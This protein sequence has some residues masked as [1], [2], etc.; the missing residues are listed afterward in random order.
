[1]C[2]NPKVRKDLTYMKACNAYLSK[3]KTKYK[4]SLKKVLNEGG[5]G[6]QADKER[7]GV[8]FDMPGSVSS[9]GLSFL[10]ACRLFGLSK[11]FQ[12]GTKV[13]NFQ[14][15]YA[16]A[17]MLTDVNLQLAD[18]AQPYDV[19]FINFPDNFIENHFKKFDPD[20]FFE[21]TDKPEMAMVWFDFKEKVL[22][23]EVGFSNN[24]VI[25]KMFSN[26]ERELNEM[27]EHTMEGAEPVSEYELKV[28]SYAFRVA[29]NAML[30]ADG[31][32][33]KKGYENQDYADRL[34]KY[35]RKGDTEDKKF[36]ALLDKQTL[37]FVFNYSRRTVTYH[38]S[39]RVSEGEP[40]GKV[41]GPHWRRGHYR[42]QRFGENLSG[43]KIVRI[44]PVFVNLHWVSGIDL[45]KTVTEYRMNNR[46]PDNE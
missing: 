35:I 7:T 20:N 27:L 11:V 4:A 13:L 12:T 39:R 25:C 38:K 6:L 18:Y 28:S 36:T 5:I 44:A 40:T 2:L 16:D 14:Q 24:V 22:F 46:R 23:V 21:V 3:L 33:D 9:L 10:D 45:G 26:P 30:T 32:L 15:D 42:I 1:M 43:S 37:P 29:L 34:D 8:N 19:M 41:M 17:F 31:H